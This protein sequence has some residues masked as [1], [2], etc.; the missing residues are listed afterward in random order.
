M[1]KPRRFGPMSSDA[2]LI[3]EVCKACQKPFKEGDY[4]TLVAIGPGDDPE[5]QAKARDGRYY[6]AVA[7]VAHWSCVTGELT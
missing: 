5:E 1:E 2:S 3:G 7:L 6:N 4:T